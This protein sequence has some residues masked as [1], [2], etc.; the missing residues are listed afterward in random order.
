MFSHLAIHEKIII[1]CIHAGVLRNW[2]L[3]LN[4]HAMMIHN[5]IRNRA[6]LTKHNI[7]T[8]IHVHVHMHMICYGL[9]QERR[10]RTSIHDHIIPLQKR[11]QISHA[12]YL[13]GQPKL[14][15]AAGL[16]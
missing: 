8:H 13:W 5:I 14:E 16:I 3:H 7:A 15:V 1:F 10:A 6:I 9:M 11:Y 2:Y 4:V 12:G